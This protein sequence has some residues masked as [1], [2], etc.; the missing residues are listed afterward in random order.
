M[1]FIALIATLILVTSC[2][3][4]LTPNVDKT[5]PMEINNGQLANLLANKKELVLIDV[6]TP[7]EIAE[8]KISGAIEI[9]YSGDDFQTKVDELDKETH[10]VIYCRS[11]NRSV[12]SIAIMKEKGFKRCTNL[13][14]GYN[15][16]SAQ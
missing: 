15:T 14:G 4:R 12:K 1:K 7:K 5:I 6:R 3:P 8:G 10:Y 2:K 16:W 9:D 13:E 11:G